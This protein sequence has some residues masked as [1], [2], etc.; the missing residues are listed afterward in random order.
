[1][2]STTLYPVSVSYIAGGKWSRSGGNQNGATAAEALSGL[3]TWEPGSSTGYIYRKG[4]N[5][6]ANQDDATMN[7]H[8]G[9]PGFAGTVLG[10][11]VNC[12]ISVGNT[13]MYGSY[14]CYVYSNKDA[15]WSGAATTSTNSWDDIWWQPG[16][17]TDLWGLHSGDIDFRDI[18]VSLGAHCNTG[19][20]GYSY[21][22]AYQYMDVTV[23]YNPTYTKVLSIDGA[24]WK[25]QT[26]VISMDASLWK[27]QTKSLEADALLYKK[28]TLPLS[29]DAQLFKGGIITLEM[30]AALYKTQTK[31]TELDA[32][33]TVLRTSQV[34]AD[35]LLYKEMTLSL[36]MDAF[37]IWRKSQLLSMDAKI[38]R[39][40]EANIRSSILSEDRPDM[41]IGYDRVPASTV[42]RIP[43]AGTKHEKPA[44]S[45]DTD[46][47]KMV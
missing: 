31:T 12:G 36:S 17:A 1:M 34:V 37:T 8:L 16:G 4:S 30:D 25:Q 14:S 22:T 21:D 33:L 20:Y 32:M 5:A 9:D 47:Q 2:A 6:A 10:I 45:I 35:A 13:S 7:V 42:N 23:W 38:W 40:Q 39:R 19:Q 41:G 15:A 28:F 3:Q 29:M 24:L 26:G 44:F 18:I 27:I 46:Q 11:R 43:K